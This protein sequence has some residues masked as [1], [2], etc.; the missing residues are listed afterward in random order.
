LKNILGCHFSVCVKANH[1]FDYLTVT[2]YYNGPVLLLEDDHY[3]VK[4]LIPVLKQMYRLRQR[5]L[6]FRL[7]VLLV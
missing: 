7:F 6:N 3:V 4:D 5:W 1:V 2:E